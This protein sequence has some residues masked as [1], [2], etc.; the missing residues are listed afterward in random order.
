MDTQL[1]T[2]LFATTLSH[3]A[4]V[5]AIVAMLN[6]P[7]EGGEEGEITWGVPVMVWD[8]PGQAK[9][10]VIADRGRSMYASVRS[11]M[12]S[13]CE[14]AD[15]GGFPVA[16]KTRDAVEKLPDVAV[17]D[18]VQADSALMILDE[19]GS[20]DGARMAAAQTLLTE[21]MAGSTRVPGHVRIIG[22]G[23][24]PGVATAGEP[25]SLPAAN[26]FLHCPWVA[27]KREDFK[28][29]LRGG[30]VLRKKSAKVSLAD[31]EAKVEAAWPEQY[32]R[33]AAFVCG[34]LDRFEDDDRMGQ[35]PLGYGLQADKGEPDELRWLS[36]RTYSMLTH[37]LAG[38]FCHGL[39]DAQIDYLV[40]STMPEGA[41]TRFLAYYRDADLPR[42]Q[43]ALGNP[44]GVKITGR[45]DKTAAILDMSTTFLLGYE[46]EDREDLARG[47]WALVDRVIESPHGGKELV[48]TY[49]RTVALPADR[50][51]CGL[52]QQAI[53]EA[54]PV[55]AK[56]YDV[57]AFKVKVRA[58]RK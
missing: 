47:F 23:N 24:P 10:S 30:G 25:F 12:L 26:R 45:L 51:G 53:P 15:I 36:P 18:L 37:V 39:S 3:D 55:I 33:A 42:P 4:A 38:A 35:L 49:A 52:G 58:S 40:R 31:I 9:S 46:G 16:N 27:P 57:L 1:T 32:A 34:Y 21:R 41:A 6:T 22:I 17:R 48:D 5:E 28:A 11:W 54:G 7:W 20:I 14:A 56:L 44:D 50:G 29:H 43:E 2:T 8:E 19:L 13:Q